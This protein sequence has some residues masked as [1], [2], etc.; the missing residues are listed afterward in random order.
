MSR[1]GLAR[2]LDRMM[3]TMRRDEAASIASASS[4]ISG[5]KSSAALTPSAE[6]TRIGDPS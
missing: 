2:A 1:L 3:M 6:K 5:G 4:S